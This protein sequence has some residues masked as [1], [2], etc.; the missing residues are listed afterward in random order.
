MLQDYDSDQE[1]NSNKS[2]KQDV[3]GKGFSVRSLQLMQKFV[4]S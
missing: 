3:A 2:S 1:E 4:T